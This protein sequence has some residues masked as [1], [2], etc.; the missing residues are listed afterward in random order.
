MVLCVCA[1]VRVLGVLKTWCVEIIGGTKR[2]LGQQMAGADAGCLFRA[3]GKAEI[4][5]LEG[6]SWVRYVHNAR[7]TL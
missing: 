1:R 5:P 6:E 2:W 3:F 4:P 7:C